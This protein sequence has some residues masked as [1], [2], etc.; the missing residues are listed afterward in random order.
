MNLVFSRPYDLARHE[1]TIHRNRKKRVQCPYCR[2]EKTFSRNDALTRHMRVYHP[3]AA[4]ESFVAD[5]SSDPDPSRGR[6][7]E[8]APQYSTHSRNS[9]ASSARSMIDERMGW[10]NEERSR[11]ARRPAPEPAS[12]FRESSPYHPGRQ[13]SHDAACGVAMPLELTMKD[14]SASMVSES[15]G[16][17]NTAADVDLDKWVRKADSRYVTCMDHRR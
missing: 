8:R 3:E 16:S 10:A 2:E 1:H 4:G 9:S 5:N 15:Q 17:S 13:K 11:S 7:L 6:P 14:Y 12:P